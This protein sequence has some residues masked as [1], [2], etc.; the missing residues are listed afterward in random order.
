MSEAH[1]RV[2]EERVRDDFVVLAV[3][4]LRTRQPAYILIEK[5]KVFFGSAP[6]ARSPPAATHDSRLTEKFVDFEKL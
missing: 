6:T 1:V 2:G 3:E 5:T 4:A